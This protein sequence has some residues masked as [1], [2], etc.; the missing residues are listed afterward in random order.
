MLAGRHWLDC[1]SD[2]VEPSPCLYCIS[3]PLGHEN[4]HNRCL[5]EA[6]RSLALGGRLPGRR[7]TAG[8]PHP[9]QWWHGFC[10]QNRIG[11]L[12]FR[13]RVSEEIRVNVLVAESLHLPHSF[14]GWERYGQFAAIVAERLRCTII[15]S[16]CCIP[17]CTHP[18]GSLASLHYVNHAAIITALPSANHREHAYISRLCRKITITL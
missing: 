1:L 4:R 16:A 9:P 18:L 13:F 15:G 8:K 2:E 6:C 11:A 10:N 5:I 14:Q 12:R 3:S 7:A 17:R